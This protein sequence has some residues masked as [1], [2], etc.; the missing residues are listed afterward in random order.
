M[1]T[2]VLA[3]VLDQLTRDTSTE[4]DTIKRER[5]GDVP[6]IVIDKGRQ[7]VSA[8]EIVN[9][10]EKTQPAPYRRKGLYVAASVQSLL[11]WMTAN[12]ADE[13]PVFGVGLEKLNGE[14]RQ[15]KLSLIG[16]GNYSSKDKAAWHDF[17]ARYNFPV[18]QAW[19][20]WAKLHSDEDEPHWFGQ[21][22][23]AQFIEDRIH[24]LSSPKRNEELT[25]AVTR[26]IEAS[27]KKDAATPAEMFK[28]SREL[29]ILSE[30]KIEAKLDLQTGETKVQY[31]AEHTGPGGRPITV[32]AMFFIRIPVFFGQEPVLIGVKL[33]YRTGG[34]KVM[35]S[36][37]LF[38]PDLVVASEFENAC[39]IVVTA[40]RILY[41]GE[42]DTR[43]V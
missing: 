27:G 31:S 3:E 4:L 25:E 41:L 14:W 36:Y 11:T 38:A 12:T 21:A 8:A 20:V 9:A 17:S 10:Y 33:R 35:W 15:P 39:K 2:K 24:D 6:F 43:A 40:G 26:F 18:S 7:M 29:K 1:E 23:F 28:V 13:A 32:P 42:P 30:E 16:I 37:S 5:D 34:G 22:D 19:N